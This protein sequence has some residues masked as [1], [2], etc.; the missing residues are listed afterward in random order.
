MYCVCVCVCVYGTRQPRGGCARVFKIS[1]PTT[2]KSYRWTRC[3]S[4][5]T[6]EIPCLPACGSKQTK[7]SGTWNRID[8]RRLCMH[9]LKICL[10]RHEI[11][12]HAKLI[13]TEWFNSTVKQW[14]AGMSAAAR[15][16]QHAWVGCAPGGN[17]A[18]HKSAAWSGPAGSVEAAR[19]RAR[20]D[21]PLSPSL[22]S[23]AGPRQWPTSVEWTSW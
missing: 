6:R 20:P 4:R 10:H 15:R 5:G 11:C 17:R 19:R 1:I 7:G 14:A 13:S 18:H 3:F 8:S 21:T 9:E 12:M 16:A 23:R 22:H 2:F